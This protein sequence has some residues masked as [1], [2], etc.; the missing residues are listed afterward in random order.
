[1]P[2]L[3]A[4]RSMR[5]SESKSTRDPAA[6]RPE[7]GLAVPAI[8]FRIV[9]LPAP[10]RRETAVTPGSERDCALTVKLPLLPLMSTSSTVIA[11]S[12][13]QASGHPFRHQHRPDRKQDRKADQAQ[14]G[15]VTLGRLQK[16]ID[17]KRKRL[18]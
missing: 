13:R 9:L 7:S 14:R 4:G 10:E 1:M 16:R 15:R 18:R 12:F 2:R 17:G 6:I 3:R 8:I 11:A 5:A